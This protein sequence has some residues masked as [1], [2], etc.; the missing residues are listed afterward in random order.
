MGVADE[1]RYDHRLLQNVCGTPW[2]PNPSDASTDLPEPML[3]IPHLPEVE[4]AP[5]KTY[6]SDNK[7]KFTA[8]GC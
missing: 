3:I 6:H 4:P 8:L 7:E 2:E 1:Q 5:T